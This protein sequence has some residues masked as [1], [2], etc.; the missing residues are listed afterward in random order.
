[1]N[2]L[3]SSALGRSLIQPVRMHRA[4]QDWI[5]AGRPAP[6][7]HAIKIRNILA[8]ADLYAIDTFIETGTFR[9]EMIDAVKD[10]F[11]KIYSIEIFGPLATA[12]KE[13]FRGQPHIR[14]VEGDSG[15]KLPEVMRDA[16][17][18]AVFWLDGHYS[19]AGTGMTEIESPILKEV[20]E[21]L[22]HRPRGQDL[23]IIDDARCFDGNSGYPRIN[24]FMVSLHEQLG[25]KPRVADD[26][27][28]ILPS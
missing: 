1:M 11:K 12:A 28:F 26:A 16:P 24:D 20:A 6:V 13:K 27:V 7:P 3:R 23:I 22:A 9:G 4:V 25:S 21:I 19:G 2:V 15:A 5:Q 8:L 14:I 17:E 18:P 10:R